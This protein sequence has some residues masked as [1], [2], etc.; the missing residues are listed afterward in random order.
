[1]LLSFKTQTL[2][3]LLVIPFLFLGND[4]KAQNDYLNQ[5]YTNGRNYYINGQYEYVYKALEPH[6][7]SIQVPENFDYYKRSEDGVGVVFRVYKMII[8][9][10]YALNRIERA[11]WFENWVINYY[12]GIYTA[13]EVFDYLD[14]VQL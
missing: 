12:Y 6:V 5:A 13:E 14:Y 1:M 3:I 7:N 4:V 10:E 2:Q 9:S 8:E 11:E